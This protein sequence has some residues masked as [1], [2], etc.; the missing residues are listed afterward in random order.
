MER[1]VVGDDVDQLLHAAQRV[2]L[3]AALVAG[4]RGHDHRAVDA[5]DPVRGRGRAATGARGDQQREDDDQDP[6]AAFRVAEED[7]EPVEDQPDRSEPEKDRQEEQREG[8]HG[9]RAAVHPRAEDFAEVVRH[10]AAVADEERDGEDGRRQRD[11]QQDRDQEIGA[12]EKPR[13]VVAKDVGES[14]RRV[15]AAP[16]PSSSR[17]RRRRRA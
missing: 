6:L 17:R 12:A 5:G 16:P 11:G 1:G 8:E 9:D 4:D 10:G 2:R 3:V 13:A 7:D 14:A 15:R